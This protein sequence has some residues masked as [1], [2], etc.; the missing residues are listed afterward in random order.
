MKKK[1]TL[2]LNEKE[3]N[4]I[5][6]V[7]DEYANSC[8]DDMNGMCGYIDYDGEKQ[9]KRINAKIQKAIEENQT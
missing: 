8:Y 7:M 1:I 9:A 6:K 4:F 3:A 2:I 5:T